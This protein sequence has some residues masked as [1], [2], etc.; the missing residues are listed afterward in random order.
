M[1]LY[2]EW[3]TGLSMV[4]FEALYTRGFSRPGYRPVLRKVFPVKVSLEYAIKGGL[5]AG[6]L[7]SFEMNL[8]DVKAIAVYEMLS[9][10]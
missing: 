6:A 4:L 10:V 2:K 9:T 3:N 5:A 7:R 8:F 1:S